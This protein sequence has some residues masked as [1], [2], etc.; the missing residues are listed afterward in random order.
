[1]TRRDWLLYTDAINPD[2]PA[3][4]TVTLVRVSGSGAA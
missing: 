4:E 1:M 2:W 3:Q